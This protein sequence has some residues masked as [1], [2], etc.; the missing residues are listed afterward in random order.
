MLGAGRAVPPGCLGRLRG[1]T[2]HSVFQLGGGEGV[3]VHNRDN[4]LD[5]RFRSVYVSPLSLYSE[6]AAAHLNIL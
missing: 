5:L 4:L 6:L 1:S 3:S 2:Q